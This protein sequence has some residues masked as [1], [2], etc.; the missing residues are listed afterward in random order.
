MDLCPP[1]TA[2]FVHQG[3]TLEHNFQRQLH[4]E[5]LAGTDAGRA[6]KIS[7]GVA[8]LPESTSN[9][10]GRRRQV[11][12]VEQIEKLDTELGAESFGDGN[13]LENGEINVAESRRV[14]GIASH[15]PKRTLCRIGVRVRIDPLDGIVIDERMRNA[16]ER[17]A[18][19]DSS[20]SVFAS[21]IGIGRGVDAEWKSGAE[22]E[23]GIQLPS[24]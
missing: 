9:E 12:A 18:D 2:R 15:S 10:T 13:V 1:W 11:D 20:R 14:D 24:V 19:L 23:V 8:A 17:I 7:G 22:G 3:A 16:L 21:P 6:V 5:R 4:V